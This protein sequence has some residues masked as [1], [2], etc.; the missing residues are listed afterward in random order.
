MTLSC[1]TPEEIISNLTSLIDNPSLCKELITNQ[2][3]YINPDSAKDLIEL[4]KN[5]YM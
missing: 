3:K 5:N 4:I 2:E 1:Q